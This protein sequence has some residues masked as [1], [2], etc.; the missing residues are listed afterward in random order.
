MYHARAD[1]DILD[2]VPKKTRFGLVIETKHLGEKIE[3]CTWPSGGWEGSKRV[4]INKSIVLDNLFFE[5]L[6]LWEGDGSKSKGLYF[7]NSCPDLLL[8]F[9]QFAEEKLGLTRDKFK[10]T[11]C[12]PQ[13][14]DKWSRKRWSKIL[15]I[16]IHNFT[17][18]CH[19]T[20]L[21]RE[22]AMMYFNSEILVDVMKNM[23]EKLKPAIL[24]KENS[25][26][27]FLRGLFAAEGSVLSKKSGVL[28]HITFSS[29]DLRLINF[30]RK[31]LNVCGMSFGSYEVNGRNLQIY[32]WWNFRRFKELGIHTLHPEKR[33]KFEQGFASYK[34]INV[35]E[36]EE[37]RTFIL[38][39]LASGPKTYDELATALGKART[40]IQAW[41]IPILEKRG[42]IKRVGKRGRAWLWA[43]AEGKSSAP[44]T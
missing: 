7:S 16:P 29:K 24:K 20:R 37:A 27:S 13:G 2:F 40:T 22:Y 19:D 14:T 1:F 32:G 6:G 35:L 38:R 17:K 31:C 25:A 42:S 36:G 12:V 44:P 30:V 9:L 8:V 33:E 43:P 28:H 5:S 15:G 41:H 23:L 34:R 4:V 11:L 21:S 26:A 18:L 39:Q 10:V 3:L